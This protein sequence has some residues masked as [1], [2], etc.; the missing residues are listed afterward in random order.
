LQ[1]VLSTGS[2]FQSGSTSS[3]RV[4]NACSPNRVPSV[5]IG[6]LTVEHFPGRF[7]MVIPFPLIHQRMQDQSVPFACGT[8]I[9]GSTPACERPL[10]HSLSQ[11]SRCPPAQRRCHEQPTCFERFGERRSSCRIALEMWLSADAV[12]PN[13]V[14][15][16]LGL[17]PRKSRTDL[18]NELRCC[19]LSH[20]G[21]VSLNSVV[22]QFA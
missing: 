4:V 11:Q 18:S 13:G 10:I 8:A 22:S 6:F 16:G 20:S 3:V 15:V 12:R 21:R 19:A 2:A 17:G 9:P 1:I 14:S 7:R 5:L